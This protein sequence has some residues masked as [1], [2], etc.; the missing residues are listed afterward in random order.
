M[1]RPLQ[2]GRVP[3]GMR[4]YAVCVVA[5][6]TGQFV[7]D[8]V[9]AKSTL[10]SFRVFAETHNYDFM[11]VFSMT[12]KKYRKSGMEFPGESGVY[13]STILEQ[14]DVFPRK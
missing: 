6:D 2:V 14:E 9:K 12:W 4:Y 3:E 5:E 13:R 10:N 11:A 7:V 8:K 1:D